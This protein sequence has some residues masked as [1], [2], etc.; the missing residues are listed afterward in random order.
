MAL[1]LT[2]TLEP[3]RLNARLEAS[4]IPVTGTTLTIERTSPSGAVAGVR[5]AVDVNLGGN[6]TSYRIRDYELPLDTTVTYTATVY[7]G[8]TV[9]ATASAIFSIAYGECEAWLTDLAA[10]TN[11]LPLT[12][13]SM[14]TLTSQI[15]SGIYRVLNRRAPVVVALQAWSPGTELIVLTDTLYERDRVRALCGSGY[16]FLVRTAPEQGIGNTYLAP[17][18]LVEERFLTLGEAAQRRFRITCV[19]IER[20][21]PSIYVPIPPNDYTKAKAAYATYA[22]L[23]AGV[24]DYDELAYTYPVGAE[25]ISPWLPD[26]V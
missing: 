17:S 25:P 2:V 24:A 9:V 18:E 12:L 1:A 26:D 3:E 21:D 5:G 14:S 16:P 23:T 7:E 19:Q 20:P 22:D 11:S 4:G 8:S 10:P 6:V 15:S 13:E